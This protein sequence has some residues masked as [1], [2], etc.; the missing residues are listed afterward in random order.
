MEC[1]DWLIHRRGDKE[2]VQSG[3]WWCCEEDT[4]R[5]DK[6]S[7]SQP[8]KKHPGYAQTAKSQRHKGKLY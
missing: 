3:G 7:G 5:I 4:R 6:N 8:W 1:T 2:V